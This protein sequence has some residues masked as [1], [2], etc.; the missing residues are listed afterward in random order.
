MG[1]PLPSA[2]DGLIGRHLGTMKSLFQLRK[3]QIRVGQA[4]WQRTKSS[5]TPTGRVNRHFFIAAIDARRP[6]WE[7]VQK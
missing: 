6:E 4:L 3:M 7:F 1:E 5:I 2:I